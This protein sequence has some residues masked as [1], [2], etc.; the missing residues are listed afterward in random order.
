MTGPEYYA[1][2]IFHIE[3]KMYVIVNKMMVLSSLQTTPALPSPGKEKTRK[4]LEKTKN[5]TR[6]TKNENC[7]QRMRRSS[8]RINIVLCF[9]INDKDILYN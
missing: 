8:M 5:M 3:Y 7:L 9:V 2:I 1:Y 6:V 4:D